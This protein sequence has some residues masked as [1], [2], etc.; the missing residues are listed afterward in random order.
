MNPATIEAVTEVCCYWSL[1][2]G[3]PQVNTPEGSHYT[4]YEGPNQ[5]NRKLG[6]FDRKL[7]GRH[8]VFYCFIIW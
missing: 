4:L 1:N 2:W 5:N 3:Q 8:L 7:E 6:V